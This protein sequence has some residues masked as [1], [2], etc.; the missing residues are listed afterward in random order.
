MSNPDLALVDDMLD[1]T[2]KVQMSK[3][4]NKFNFIRKKKLSISDNTIKKMVRQPTKS[5][6]FLQ[7]YIWQV[8]SLIPITLVGMWNGAAT[9]ENSLAVLLNYKH[10]VTTWLSNSTPVL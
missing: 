9:S 6:K 10:Q 2:P 8:P 3:E 7:S 4:K 5:E 1:T